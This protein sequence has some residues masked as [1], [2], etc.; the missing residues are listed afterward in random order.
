MRVN[1]ALLLRTVAEARRTPRLR[2]LACGQAGAALDIDDIAVAARLTEDE[3]DLVEA[4]AAHKGRF[5]NS[6]QLADFIY[7]RRIDGGPDNVKLAICHLVRSL[8]GKLARHAKRIT[9]ESYPGVGYR[10]GWRIDTRLGCEGGY[11][12]M[13]GQA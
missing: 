11:R 8:R 3:A 9:V 7:A 10:I 2:C 5:V 12:L 1:R 13:R 4:L 6:W